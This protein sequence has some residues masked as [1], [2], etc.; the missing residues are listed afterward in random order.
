[1]KKLLFLCLTISL[2]GCSISD[3]SNFAK[4]DNSELAKT[5][6]DFQTFNDSI[7]GCPHSNTNYV[8]TRS[9]WKSFK[10]ALEVCGADIIGAGEGIAATSKIASA[11][12]AATGGTAGVAVC[13]VGGIIC[14]AGS[15]LLAYE[16]ISNQT[17]VASYTTNEI[18]DTYSQ[19]KDCPITYIKLDFPERFNYINVMGGLHNT[20][21]IN[22]LGYPTDSIIDIPLDS[23][24]NI[25][26]AIYVASED[27]TPVTNPAVQLEN[28]AILVEE[29]LQTTLDN[30][31]IN[32]EQTE[33]AV[34]KN[35]HFTQSCDTIIEDICT[36]YA[37]NTFE[38]N[39]LITKT[40]YLTENEKIIYNLYSDLYYSY[41][42]NINEVITIANGYIKRIESL[43]NFTEK[44][45]EKL[46]IMISVSVN[47]A[48]YWNK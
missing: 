29:S 38:N 18:M 39:T 20:I 8:S 33:C 43:T 47:S 42:E 46:F 1:M 35:D 9:F 26:P 40:K 25:K 6:Q 21:L 27:Y 12:G 15:S 10:K 28:E 32:Y 36:A 3:E 31:S 2:L 11:I 44:E 22:T 45:K 37:Y 34:L 14:G 13:A 48:Y 4:S 30:Y 17:C 19:I 24:P 7:L 5:I 23:F 41:P 16:T